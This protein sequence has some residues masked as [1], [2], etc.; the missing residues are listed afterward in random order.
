MSYHGMESKYASMKKK[1]GHNRE[2]VRAAQ[3]GEGA[4]VITGRGKIDILRPDGD[5]ESVKGG[6]R[7]QWA[8][9]CENRIKDSK[10]S[11]KGKLAFSNWINFLPKDKKEYLKNPKLFSKNSNVIELYNE[12]GKKPMELIKYFC[13]YDDI[14][15]YVL[16]DNRDNTQLILTKDEFFD[17]IE[18]SIKRV[19][20]TPGGKLSIAGG[21]K[22]ILLFELELRKG[23]NSHRGVLFVSTLKHII[24][25][26]K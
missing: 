7:T 19:Y 25:L 24:D 2:Y 6:N 17:K 13:G 1:E 26:F 10:F 12:Y 15:Y 4:E 18:K 23:K 9:Y 5:R 22:D 3:L 11:K 8:L 20:T 16:M 14:N 21:P